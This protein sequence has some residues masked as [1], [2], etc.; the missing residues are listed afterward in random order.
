MTAADSFAHCCIYC[1]WLRTFRTTNLMVLVAWSGSD[2]KGTPKSYFFA[3]ANTWPF[4]IESLSATPQ[5]KKSKKKKSTCCWGGH[6]RSVVETTRVSW[7]DLPFP[8]IWARKP[9]TAGQQKI[10][11]T[12]DVA[13]GNFNQFMRGLVGLVFKMLLNSSAHFGPLVWP[14]QILRRRA[15]LTIRSGGVVPEGTIGVFHPGDSTGDSAGDSTQ[16]RERN[17]STPLLPKWTWI[18]ALSWTWYRL[19]FKFWI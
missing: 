11:Q 5:G 18:Q 14:M 13:C 1:H 4:P 2:L 10:W 16:F 9:R 6:F 17:I 19:I 12:W 3:P 15:K 8:W 7:P